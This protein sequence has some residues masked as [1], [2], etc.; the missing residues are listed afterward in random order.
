MK[1]EL[2]AQVNG[3]LEAVK[4]H[5]DNFGRFD[6]VT[7]INQVFVSFE[8][9]AQYLNTGS[10]TDVSAKELK[11]EAKKLDAQHAKAEEAYERDMAEAQKDIPIE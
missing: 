6:G 2:A 8:G 3:Y 5:N 1:E 4:Y 11:A 7:P 9:F 10:V